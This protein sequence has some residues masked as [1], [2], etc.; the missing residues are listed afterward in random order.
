MPIPRKP[1]FSAT[2]WSL[3]LHARDGDDAT[4][5]PAL[6]ELCRRYWYPLYA[7]VRRQGRDAEEAGDLTQAFFEKL[8]EKEWL[9]SV[10][11]EKGRFRSFLL[12]AMGHFLANEWNRLRRQKRGGGR[13]VVALDALEAEERYRLEPVSSS[14]PETL[15]ERRW[16]L[17]VLESA[18]RALEA[19]CNASGRGAL[20]AALRPHLSGDPDAELLAVLAPPLGTTEGALK[21]AAHR[22]RRRYGELVRAEIANTV[23]ADPA[24]V[25]AEL[26]HL[27]EALRG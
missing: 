14:T 1:E 13:P 3:I 18:F 25:D 12:T 22:L 11:P 26:R 24:T 15:Y 21:V 10:A 17:T 8:I 6:E 19:E 2:R 7:F 20:F 27:Q 16:A 9:R 4:A 23:D 5:L